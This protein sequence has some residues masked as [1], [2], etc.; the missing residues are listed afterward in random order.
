MTHARITEALQQNLSRLPLEY[1]QRVIQF[2]EALVRSLHRG[3]PGE[4]LAQLAGTLSPEDAHAMSE[5]IERAC[6]QVR[7]DE[8]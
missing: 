3:V 6:E 4:R 2:A 8:W 5:E 7:P 1:Q